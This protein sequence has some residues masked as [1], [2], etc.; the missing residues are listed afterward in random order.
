MRFVT[1]LSLIMACGVAAT[2]AA[3]R[4]EG[5][6]D[7]TRAR[8][9][10]ARLA[11]VDQ[12]NV[13]AA[14][15][16]IHTFLESEP[17]QSVGFCRKYW[18]PALIYASQFDV[19]NR[20][21]CDA[22]LAAPWQTGTVEALQETRVK[23]MLRANHPIEA[24][25][26]AR[27][28]FNVASLRG[29]ERAMLLVL[30]CLKAVHPGDNAVL[31]RLRREEL[32]G[33]T[34]RPATR[35]NQT[36]GVLAEI[37]IDPSPYA[38]AISQF[39]SDDD[40]S[41]RAKGNLLL[42]AGRCDEALAIFQAMDHSSEAVDRMGLAENVARALKACDGTIGRANGCVLARVETQIAP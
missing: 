12:A 1:A 11:D 15:D 20:L 24:L 37:S 2:R 17:D 25:A 28:L 38:A 23:L 9:L 34:T 21:A 40:Q 42:L 22:I 14:I 6:S 18:L 39:A 26:N 31:G 3:G 35:V 4:E 41:Q 7:D 30:Q 36:S 10:S 8:D 19:A 13:D 27:S 33:A 29:T 32:A 5:S 16:E